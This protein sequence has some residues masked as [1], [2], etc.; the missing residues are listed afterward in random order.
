M[1]RIKSF[2][3]LRVIFCITIFL[4]H[5]TFFRECGTMSEIVFET[6][7]HN[8]RFGVT[9]FFVLSAFC[10]YRSKSDVDIN[11]KNYIQFIYDRMKKIYP[12]YIVTMLFVAIMQFVQGVSLKKIVI[13][14]I[15]SFTLLQTSTLKYWGILNSVAWYLSTLFILYLISPILIRIVNIISQKYIILCLV[16]LLLSITIMDITIMQIEEVGLITSETGELLNY[17]FPFYWIPAYVSGM[18]I[19]RIK[20]DIKNYTLLELLSIVIS[21]IT[22]LL[23]INGPA[24]IRDYKSILYVIANLFMIYIFSFER[25]YF[26]QKLAQSKLF[27]MS[28][29]TTEVYLIHYVVIYYGGI[30]VL[31][32]VLF[33]FVGAIVA[34]II[35][36]LITLIISLIWKKSMKCIVNRIKN[37]E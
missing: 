15:L 24:I 30:Q 6:L 5:C 19:S 31:E 27:F 22:Y 29:M 8:G 26:S 36:F 33:G 25:G 37:D 2:D 1:N 35:L 23:G 14:I 21:I 13:N 16:V 9:F 4:N 28:E 12:L 10:L 3:A 18:L 11:K 34:T 20:I 17:V 7:F 32:R